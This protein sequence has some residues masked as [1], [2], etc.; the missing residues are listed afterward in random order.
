MQPVK[1]LIEKVC[2]HNN[3]EC[4]EPGAIRAA[5]KLLSTFL[6]G[7]YVFVYGHKY[8]DSI[9][10]AKAVGRDLSQIYDPTRYRRLNHTHVVVLHYADLNADEE[11]HQQTFLKYMQNRENVC[12][13]IITDWK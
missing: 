7:H 3:I 13:W 9:S 4:L 10:F 6:P 12:V 8:V 2:N 5:I 11:F 1:A